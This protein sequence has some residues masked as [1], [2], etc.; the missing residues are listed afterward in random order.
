MT[1]AGLKHFRAD[2]AKAE[3]YRQAKAL[4]AVNP[5]TRIAVGNVPISVPA[6]GGFGFDPSQIHPAGDADKRAVV[7]EKMTAAKRLLAARG[8]SL[9]DVLHA[10]TALKQVH[11]KDPA[12]FT[13]YISAIETQLQNAAKASDRKDLTDFIHGKL[14]ELARLR[15]KMELFAQLPSARGNKGGHGQMEVHRQTMKTGIA[16]GLPEED[17]VEVMASK[18]GLKQ[19][20]VRGYLRSYVRESQELPRLAGGGLLPNL[21]SRLWQHWGG[22]QGLATAYG[23]STVPALLGGIAGAAIGGPVGVLVGSTVGRIGGM[24]G[25]A[26]LL[27]Q[28][29]TL[30]SRLWQHWGGGQGLATAYGASTAPALLG[31]IAGAAIGGPVGV[32]VGSTVGRIGGMIGMAELLAQE[33]GKPRRRQP[34]LSKPGLEEL[35]HLESGAALFDHIAKNGRHLEQGSLT[36]FQYMDLAPQAIK[37]KLFAA[38]PDATFMTAGTEAIVLRK[39][40]GSIVRIAMLRQKDNE[41][42]RKFTGRPAAP[43]ILQPEKST[44][45]GNFLIEELPHVKPLGRRKSC[46][47]VSTVEFWLT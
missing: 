18:G 42:G 14:G 8:A 26:E 47:L 30:L 41:G 2:F 11:L 28:E 12:D 3:A 37:E 5:Q 36:T 13:A 44:R 31:G 19:K 43:S 35:P 9:T 45:V 23:A 4:A 10:S 38:I 32:L 24:I 46:S 40:D 22:G 34:L 17:I 33:R 21:L 6:E 20:T 29:P 25:M 39:P 16:L 27:A 15:H 1:E 7:L